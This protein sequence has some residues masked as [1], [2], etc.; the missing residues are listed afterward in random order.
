M[1]EQLSEAGAAVASRPVATS[2]YACAAGARWV[3]AGKPGMRI[4]RLYEDAARGERTLLVELGPG[5]R[6][7]PHAHEAL[8]QIY[9]LEGSFHDGQRLLRA[10]DYCCRGPGAVHEG[11]TEEGALVL[12]IYTPDVP[13]A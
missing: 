13:P 12:V 10:G 3:D 1:A 4:R 11:W 9:V 2:A 7:E 8:E 6:S 5:V